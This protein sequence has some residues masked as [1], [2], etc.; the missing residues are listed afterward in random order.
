[1]VLFKILL[2]FNCL[3]ILLIIMCLQSAIV[4]SVLATGDG[5]GGGGDG[6]EGREGGWEAKHVSV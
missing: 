1:M 4:T 5:G 3:F 2:Y 6:A